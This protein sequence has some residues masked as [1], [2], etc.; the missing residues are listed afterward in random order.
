MSNESEMICHPKHYN[1][2]GRMECIEEMEE[3]YGNEYVK[4]FCLLSA[5]KYNYR[6]GL[7]EG[8]DTD[9]GKRTWYIEEYMRRGGEWDKVE[10]IDYYEKGGI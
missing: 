4:I 1:R 7:K 3:L 8:A 5:Y 2:E 6:D 10:L 9:I